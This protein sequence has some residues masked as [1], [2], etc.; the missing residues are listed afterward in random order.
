[1]TLADRTP[2]TPKMESRA[3]TAPLVRCAH[4]TKYF[5]GVRALNNVSLNHAWGITG[6]SRDS[7]TASFSA[8]TERFPPNGRALNN[9][10]LNNIG[11]IIEYSPA[12]AS[13]PTTASLRQH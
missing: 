9:V 4:I 12:S 8:T 6:W 7:A 2:D 5:G 11:D 3:S 13:S 1:M 10:S